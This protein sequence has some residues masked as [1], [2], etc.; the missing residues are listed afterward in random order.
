MRGYLSELNRLSLSLKENRHENMAIRLGIF[1]VPVVYRR[2]GATKAQLQGRRTIP[3][4]RG[5]Q[6][7]LLERYQSEL[8]SKQRLLLVLSQNEPRHSLL[9]G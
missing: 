4:F 6:I 7:Y 8:R 2:H 1:V 9:L 5:G 3:A